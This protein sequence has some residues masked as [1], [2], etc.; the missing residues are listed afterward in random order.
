MEHTDT[1]V[2]GNLDVL[3]LDLSYE[4]N[5]NARLSHF[6]NMQ[7]VMVT[8]IEYDFTDD[9]KLRE[10]ME[11]V[12][13]QGWFGVPYDMSMVTTYVLTVEF[14]ESFPSAVQDCKKYLVHGQDYQDGV[15]LMMWYLDLYLEPVDTRVRILTDTE[16]NTIYYIKI[17]EGV[18]KENDEYKVDKNR[19]ERL[20]YWADSVPYYFEYYNSY[21]EADEASLDSEYGTYDDNVPWFIESE[22]DGKECCEVTFPLYYGELS[23]DFQIRAE[24]GRG[25]YPN[26]TMGIPLIGEK[27]PEMMQ[28]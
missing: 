2:R 5:I 10:V 27:I 23:T 14:W 26:L 13:K 1:K 17:T 9:S 16:T 18:T 11:K 25:I 12:L 6:L 24:L 22:T 15:A 28:D 20:Y 8:P 19:I 4:Q 3:R 7:E 21:Y